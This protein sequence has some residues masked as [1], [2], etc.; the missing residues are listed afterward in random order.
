MKGRRAIMRGHGARLR[1]D[2][3]TPSRPSAFTLIELLVVITVIVVLLA[4]LTPALD[5]AITRAELAVCASR[6]HGWG[7]A[8]GQYYFDNQRKILSI[9]NF[10]KGLAQG[11]HPNHIRWRHTTDAE[12]GDVNL[13]DIAPYIQG[14]NQGPNNQA[15]YVGEAWYCPS[16]KSAY[17]YKNIADQQAKQIGPNDPLTDW[18]SFMYN[19]YAYYG[20]GASKYPKQITRP[21]LLSNRSFGEGRILM[22]DTIF[23]FATSPTGWWYN[24]SDNGYSLHEPSF[25]GPA[26][27][28][29]P[30]TGISVNQL[31]ADSSVIW[32]GPE[33][34]DPAAMDPI[35]DKRFVDFVSSVT[36]SPEPNANVNIY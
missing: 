3:M 19:D 21:Q 34:F 35:P 9:P 28:G 26:H 2:F 22:S 25:G 12:A 13:D 5:K 29:L 17:W 31:Y 36:D 6:L 14:P 10:R 16:N 15:T 7:T 33:H 32:K 18:I 27:R 4:L 1:E 20:M 24:H 23:R 11:V 8:H 30:S